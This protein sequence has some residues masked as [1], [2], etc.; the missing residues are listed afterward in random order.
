MPMTRCK[1]DGEATS[2]AIMPPRPFLSNAHLIEVAATMASAAETFNLFGRV[3]FSGELVIIGDLLSSL[4]VASGVHNN[5][6]PIQY[7]SHAGGV[8]RVIDEPGD[9]TL[10]GSIDYMVS[11]EPKEV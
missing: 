7:A 6:P 11:G 1:S 10:V 4:D 5:P 8:A 2:Y 9:V 3:V